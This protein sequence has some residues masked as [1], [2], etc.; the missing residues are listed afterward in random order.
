[1]RRSLE[2][3]LAP[4]EP[5][6]IVAHA[7]SGSPEWLTSGDWRLFVRPAPV[8]EKGEELARFTAADGNAYKAYRA[9]DLHGVFVPFDLDEAFHNY[10]SEA[11]SAGVGQRRL[12][13]RQLSAFYS[14]KRFIP[15]RAQLFGR[16]A[17]IR[18]QGLPEFPAW[19]LDRSVA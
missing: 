19:P 6:H 18:W 13:S 2:R 1:V 12:S 16:R 9:T 11:W 17:L 7:G 4:L 5:A 15:R 10:V 8:D 14:L 3:L